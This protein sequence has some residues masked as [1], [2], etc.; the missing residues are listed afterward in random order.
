MNS[1][2]S[3]TRLPLPPVVPS[4]SATP[5]HRSDHL[6][7]HNSRIAVAHRKWKRRPRRAAPHRVIVIVVILYT[8]PRCLPAFFPHCPSYRWRALCFFPLVSLSLPRSRRGASLETR[9]T[10]EPAR[11]SSFLSLGPPFSKRAL[12]EKPRRR[13]GERGEGAYFVRYTV[14]IDQRDRT[15]APSE[16]RRE[17][18]GT[19][20]GTAH[21]GAKGRDQRSVTEALPLALPSL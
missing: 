11:V 13:R 3:D 4:L 21:P 20:R 15:T 14:T 6:F 18:V 16:P 9:T 12:K 7:F 19:D 5:F 1:L 2:N 10:S 8:S 17:N